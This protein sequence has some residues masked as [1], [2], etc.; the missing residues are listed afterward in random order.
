MFPCPESEQPIATDVFTLSKF[1]CLN[2]NHVCDETL[3][4]WLGHEG[5]AFI[6]GISALT[7]E[8]TGES[9]TPS[10]M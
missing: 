4:R 3:G 1:I 10:S 5:R 9:L 8:T 6:N 2:P 7:K